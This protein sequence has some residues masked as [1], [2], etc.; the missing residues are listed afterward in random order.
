MWDLIINLYNE[1]SLEVD[2]VAEDELGE[3]K[4]SSKNKTKSR[5]Q[6]LNLSI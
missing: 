5:G 6:Y 2:E 1:F 4:I 3:R